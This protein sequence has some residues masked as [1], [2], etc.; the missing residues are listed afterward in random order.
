MMMQQITALA[1]SIC[2]HAVLLCRS[3]YKRYTMA[4]HAWFDSC[5]E[6]LV[7]RDDAIHPKEVR[8]REA[9]VLLYFRSFLC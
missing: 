4:L 9:W 2:Q 7:R 6:D 5:D 3:R 8:D 1:T